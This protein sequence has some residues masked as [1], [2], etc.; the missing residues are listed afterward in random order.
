MAAAEDPVAVW[1]PWLAALPGENALAVERDPSS[2]DDGFV[3]ELGLGD[4]LPSGDASSAPPP[5]KRRKSKV[6]NECKNTPPGDTYIKHTKPGWHVVEQ[7]FT[8][9]ASKGRDA[10]KKSCGERLRDL[11]QTPK[12]IDKDEDAKA[13]IEAV[14]LSDVKGVD[15]VLKSRYEEKKKVKEERP[16]L[17]MMQFQGGTRT[18]DRPLWKWTVFSEASR[19]VPDLTVPQEQWDLSKEMQTFKRLLLEAAKHHLEFEHD[20]MRKSDTMSTA[21]HEAV[22]SGNWPV[23]AIMSE[24][25]LWLISK[26]PSLVKKYGGKLGLWAE[27]RAGWLPFHNAC[28][29]HSPAYAYKNSPFFPWLLKL[30]DFQLDKMKVE[31]L[32]MASAQVNAAGTSTG[33]DNGT[34]P[35]LPKSAKHELSKVRPGKDHA[36]PKGFNDENGHNCDVS[37]LPA[38]PMTDE[39]TEA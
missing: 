27:T 11:N 25:T 17:I 16:E 33:E 38:A 10:E 2:D 13:I 15:A 23:V 24:Y 20:Q 1:L 28:I 19:R 35:E 3:Y 39:D 30:M 26:R 21:L 32:A 36:G 29:R 7:S 37:M 22:Y 8:L 4:A 18:S 12:A 14:R 5:R 31:L 9:R 6:S 34:R